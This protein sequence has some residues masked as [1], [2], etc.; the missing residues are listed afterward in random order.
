VQPTDTARTVFFSVVL[1]ALVGAVIASAAET[2]PIP[3]PNFALG[4]A[5]VYHV[6]VALVLFAAAYV[7]I[8]TLWLAF[9]GRAFTKL[10]G[11]GGIGAEA[12]ALGDAT[13]AMEDAVVQLEQKVIQP[14]ARA[15]TDLEQRVTNLGG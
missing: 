1:A 14:L 6:E 9:Q 3:V 8:A 15:V 7:P 2:A 5:A 11:P 10:T 13:G 4:S 12:E